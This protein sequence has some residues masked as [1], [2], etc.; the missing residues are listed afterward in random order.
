MCQEVTN[1]SLGLAQEYLP[2][3]EH[4]SVP[5]DGLARPL[6]SK[7][8]AVFAPYQTGVSALLNYCSLFGGHY[9]STPQSCLNTIGVTVE[10]SSRLFSQ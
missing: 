7:S 9:E 3:I 1:D 6:P 10:G 4:Q 5:S 8:C 2:I